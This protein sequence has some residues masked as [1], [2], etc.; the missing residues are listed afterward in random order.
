MN[1]PQ[2]QTAARRAS[3][4]APRPERN[5]P[6]APGAIAPAHAPELEY[7]QE[8]RHNPNN[9]KSRWWV[10]LI[11]LAV[12]GGAGYLLYPRIAQRFKGADKAGPPP[13]RE[14]PVVAA[15]ARKGDLNLFINGLGTVTPF[16]TVTVRSRVD[17]EIMKV[18]FEEGTLVK[19]G[20][21]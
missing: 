9:H 14:V 11:V 7:A 10:W 3:E 8:P 6:A 4:V 15:T 17:G 18:A 16:K 13:K 2:T 5:G 12:L 20:D 19:E 1:P 21:P